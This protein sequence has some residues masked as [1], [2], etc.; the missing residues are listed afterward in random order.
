MEAKCEK[1]VFSAADYHRAKEQIEKSID[2]LAHRRDALPTIWSSL[3]QRAS[4]LELPERYVGDDRVMCISITNIMDFTG[5]SRD[6]IVVT[7]DSCFFRFFEN[8]MVTAYVLGE[9]ISEDIEAIRAQEVPHPSE[10]EAY[11]RNP[12]QMRRFI[13]KMRLQKHVVPRITERSSFRFM[14][15]STHDTKTGIQITDRRG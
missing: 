3:R 7:D 9:N 4:K 15:N 8:R 6:G 12:I 1:A 11:L 10:L 5:Y 2:Q 14:S 13:E